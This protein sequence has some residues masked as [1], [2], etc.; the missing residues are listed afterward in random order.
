[1]QTFEE[2]YKNYKLLGTGSVIKKIKKRK[3]EFCDSITVIGISYFSICNQ[4]SHCDMI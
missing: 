4:I 3:K 2:K 1:M